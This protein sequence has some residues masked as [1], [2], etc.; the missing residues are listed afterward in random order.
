MYS[1]FLNK[2]FRKI[3]ISKFLQQQFHFLLQHY[4]QSRKSHSNNV[5]TKLYDMNA[6]EDTLV[7][8]I[9]SLENYF[10]QE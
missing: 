3:Y 1:N 8:Y 7:E 2:K 6:S 5:K 10:I 9:T 4:N